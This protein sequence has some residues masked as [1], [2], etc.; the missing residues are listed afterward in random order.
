MCNES[1][2]CIGTVAGD[3]LATPERPFEI[4]ML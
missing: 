3:L 4:R 2:K 1:G